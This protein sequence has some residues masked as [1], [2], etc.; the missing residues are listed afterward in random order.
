MR[1]KPVPGLAGSKHLRETFSAMT[2]AKIIIIVHCKCSSRQLSNGVI[3]LIIIF[4]RQP[5]SYVSF[6]QSSSIW[7][8]KLTKKG[9]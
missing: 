4:V 9:S 2:H 3:H 7:K 6:T 5:L 8:N 1:L